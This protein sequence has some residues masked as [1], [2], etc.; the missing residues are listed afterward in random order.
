M[1]F[2]NIP[3]DTSSRAVLRRAG[4]LWWQAIEA[5]EASGAPVWKKASENGVDGEGSNKPSIKPLSPQAVQ[6]A[7]LH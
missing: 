4:R 1:D 3:Y 7:G 5:I 6:F 2:G